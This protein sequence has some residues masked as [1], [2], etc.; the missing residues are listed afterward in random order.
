MFLNGFYDYELEGTDDE[1][2]N[3]DH[4]RN[5]SNTKMLTYNCAG[6]A[7]ETFNWY[8]PVP[9]GTDVEYFEWGSF[10]EIERNAM[11]FEFVSQILADFDDVRLIPSL[12]CLRSDEY[13]FAFRVGVD[14]FHFV[15]RGR[16]GQW[17]AKRGP[18]PICRMSEESVF[19]SAWENGRYNGAIFLFAKKR[20]GLEAYLG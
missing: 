10:E 1:L 20:G 9:A 3:R 7:L 2:R 12:D 6:Y 19:K 14:D 17:Y 11:S 18:G 5:R 4:S 15:K 13:A 16:N 8:V